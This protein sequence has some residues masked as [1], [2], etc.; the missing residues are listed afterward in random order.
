MHFLSIGIIF[1]RFRT[2]W[3]LKTFLV[4]LRGRPEQSAF[5]PRCPSDRQSTSG[6]GVAPV[7]PWPPAAHGG[8]GGK[9]ITLLNDFFTTA[10]LLAKLPS[11]FLTIA[12]LKIFLYNCRIICKVIS[13][14]TF[15]V[16]DKFGSKYIMDVAHLSA[17]KK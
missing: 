14:I 2:F 15:Q 12:A 10:N 3:L 6:S 16:Y 13:K 8:P 1:S 11:K 9:L 4:T 17:L 5:V 7:R